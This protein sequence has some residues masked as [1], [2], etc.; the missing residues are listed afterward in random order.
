MNP[1][2]RN[3]LLRFGVGLAALMGASRLGFVVEH[4]RMPYCRRLAASLAATLNWVG[5][6]THYEDATISYSFGAL[7]VVTECD[8][9]VLLVL[10]FAG[11]AAAPMPR[12]WRHYGLLLLSV[13]VLLAINWVRLMALALTQL[14]YADAFDTAHHYVLQGILI[15]VTLLLYVAWLRAIEPEAA[16]GNADADPAPPA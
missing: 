10:F 13:A 6:P 14:T 9:I 2:L 12:T 11:V 8:G 1:E 3:Y 5:I 7:T 15:L 16:P 4:V